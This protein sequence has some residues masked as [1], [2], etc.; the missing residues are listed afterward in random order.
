[1]LEE[2]DA[3]KAVSPDLAQTLLLSSCLASGTSCTQ[4]VFLYNI[5]PLPGDTESI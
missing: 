5:Y 1:M 2:V 4:D 3:T